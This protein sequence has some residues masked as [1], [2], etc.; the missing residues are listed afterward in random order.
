MAVT[1]DASKDG[2]SE[3]LQRGN[4]KGDIVKLLPPEAEACFIRPGRCDIFNV[5]YSNNFLCLSSISLS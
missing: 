1:K 2:H 3:N 5:F 4:R